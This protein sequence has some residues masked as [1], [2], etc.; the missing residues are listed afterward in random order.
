V[1]QRKVVLYN[2]R[3]DFCTLP[4]ALL[5]L[6]SALDRSRYR[7]V[8]V[9]GRL[10]ERPWERVVRET[11]DA[12]CLGVTVL[13]GRP[14]R[15]A[16]RAT[17]AAKAARH[18][19]PVVWGG[20]HPSLFPLETLVEA[21]IDAT[22]QGQGEATFA[23]ILRRL[24]DGSA[25]DGV[26]GCASRRGPDIVSHGPRATTNVNEFPPLDYDLI[27]LEGYFARKGRRQ[28]DY[29]ASQGCR[30]RCTFCADPT[31]YLRSWSGLDPERIGSDLERLHRRHG[32][33]DVGFQDE[34]FFT[35][36]KRVAA[37]AAEF[38]KRALRFHWMAT[39]RA[40]QGARLE[41][42]VLA[43]C[44]NAGLRRVMVG[45]ESGSQPM[46]DW[47]KK[48]VTLE[49]VFATAEK[50]RRLSIGALFNLIVGFP[51]EPRESV[52]ETIRVAKR[53]RAMGP[54]FQVAFFYYRPYPGTEITEAL[55]RE[56]H[57]LPR[58]LGEWA[59]IEDLPSPWVDGEKRALVER[60]KFY[61]QVAW[62]RPTAMR[63]PLQALARWRCRR[64]FYGYPVEKAM[65]EWLRPLAPQG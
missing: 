43:E 17:R 35:Q 34:T 12:L 32:F 19:L 37:I 21:G 44:R 1:N 23:E 20:W 57:R 63:A 55:A 52:E 25:L 41:E 51:H 15:D 28:L 6:G 39:L 10:E 56:G 18:D 64:D 30:F 5:A 42:K 53:L 16:L 58:G 29:V 22:V 8:I 47:M 59:E 31:V 7:I 54:D 49:Q 3:A 46:L 11:E 36:G 60:F 2:P 61:Q 50:C 38:R 4:L 62:A 27:D 40:D 65:V 14:I 33:D 9:D 45:L 24:E 13:T 26:H 48:D